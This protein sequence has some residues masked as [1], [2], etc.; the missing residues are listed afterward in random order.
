MV[1]FKHFDI[2]EQNFHAVS[3][4]HEITISGGVIIT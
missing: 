3:A 4:A 1:P 2:S